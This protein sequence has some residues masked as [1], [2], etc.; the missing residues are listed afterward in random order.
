MFWCDF[1]EDR[2]FSVSSDDY[3]TPEEV[4]EFFPQVEKGDRKEVESFVTHKTFKFHPRYSKAFNRVDGTWVRKWS[5]RKTKTVKS[6]MCA[7]GFLNRQ[8][9][10]VENHSS[11]AS[12]LSH[13]LACSLGIQ[14]DLDLEAYDISTAFFQG[15]RFQ[16]MQQK[17]RELGY[18]IT[19]TRRVWLIPP[20]NFW[21]HL[22][23]I[24]IRVST[25]LIGR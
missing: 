10:S 17:A 18:D 3:L 5:C 16:E 25:S 7:R 1:H 12:R 4:T 13:R 23:H 6:R 9:Q 24:P 20:A 22:R 19:S 15:L 11:I 14:H 2:C 21:R 8:K